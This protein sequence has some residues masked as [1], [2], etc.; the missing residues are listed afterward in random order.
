[1]KQRLSQIF[2]AEVEV[3]QALPGIHY[4]VRREGIVVGFIT[5]QVSRYATNTYECYH[6]TLFEFEMALRYS[7]VSGIPLTLIVGYKDA[8][9][10]WPVDFEQ[11]GLQ[12]V[13]GSDGQFISLSI[14][15]VLMKRFNR[16]DWD[17]NTAEYLKALGKDGNKK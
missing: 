8:L 5:F 13:G 15:V 4:A 6:W 2:N 10:Y 1:M 14:P 9:M 12:W 7:Q 17:A 16:V 3:A 11:D